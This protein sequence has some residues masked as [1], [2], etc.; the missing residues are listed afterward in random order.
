ML[1]SKVYGDP[2][3]VL[4]EKKNRRTRLETNVGK[5]FRLNALKTLRYTSVEF[6]SFTSVRGNTVRGSRHKSVSFMG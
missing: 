2:S 3:V 6:I 1:G 5:Q 4:R